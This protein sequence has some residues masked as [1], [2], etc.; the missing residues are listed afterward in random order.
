MRNRLTSD[1]NRGRGDASA[2]R[3]NLF[4]GLDTPRKK[5]MNMTRIWS[6]VA[7]TGTVLSSSALLQAGQSGAPA[8]RD[9]ARHGKPEEK[10]AFF[11]LCW[12]SC[13]YGSR[14]CNYGYSGCS[15]CGGYGY[16]G[17]GYCPRPACPPCG[18]VGGCY[19]GVGYGG[20]YGGGYGGA[21]GYGGYGGY[22]G[23]PV[24]PAYP[25]PVYGA[26]GYGAPAYGAP[27]YGMPYYQGMGYN[28]DE[29]NTTSTPPSFTSKRR[30]PRP[31][32][33]E[34]DSPF[35]Q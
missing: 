32:L 14:G 11:G 5:A 10:T 8:E 34:D 13:G 1:A 22:Y 12:P 26:P 6:I 28:G 25:A 2:S 16:Y 9:T 33:A 30:N 3:K 7:V 20:A 29:N 4:N 23:A 31:A 27:A 24:A 17:S 19:G 15:P 35:F 21:C 18:P